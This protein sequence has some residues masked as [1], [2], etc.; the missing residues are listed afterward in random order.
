[1]IRLRQI[2]IGVGVFAGSFGLTNCSRPGPPSPIVQKAEAAG[3]GDLATTSDASISQWLAKNPK[4]AKEIEDLCKPVRKSAS[5]TWGDTTEGR[6]C[7]ASG[8]VAFFAPSQTTS[9]DRKFGAGNH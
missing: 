9:D 8:R 7:K 6:L 3:A 2:M 5:A 1:M 4:V